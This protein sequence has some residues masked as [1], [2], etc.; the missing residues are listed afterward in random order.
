MPMQLRIEREEAIQIF[1]L[2]R[3]VNKMRYDYR[4]CQ[5]GIQLR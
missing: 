4:K 1:R 2:A 3:V 5:N